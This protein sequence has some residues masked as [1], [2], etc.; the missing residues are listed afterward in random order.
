MD[1]KVDSQ[2]KKDII[3]EQLK[4]FISEIIGAEVVEELD[5][6]YDSV[7]TKDLEMDSIKIVA[8]AE[9]VRNYYGKKVDFISW[10]Y[11]M[12]LNKL[13]NLSLGSI[14][15]LIFDNIEKNRE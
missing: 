12:E 13:I 15:N 9:K 11:S 8:F 5:I 10:L 3:F 7:F 1:T 4:Q 2:R 14:V 6:S